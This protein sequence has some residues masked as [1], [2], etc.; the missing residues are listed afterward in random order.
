MKFIFFLLLSLCASVF[1]KDEKWVSLGDSLYYDSNSIK[2]K[3]DLT[4]IYAKMITPNHFRG[5]QLMLWVINCKEKTLFTGSK[6]IN[7]SPEGGLNDVYIQACES[8]WKFWK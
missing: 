7:I 4:E 8:K 6:S 1:A 5:E 3:G 2:R